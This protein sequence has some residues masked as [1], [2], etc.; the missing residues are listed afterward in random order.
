MIAEKIPE[1]V[2]LLKRRIPEMRA[3]I[4]SALRDKVGERVKLYHFYL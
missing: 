2:K 3:I 1:V 4:Q